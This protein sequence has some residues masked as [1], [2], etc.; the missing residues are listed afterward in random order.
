M[1]E[2]NSI[3]K[4]LMHKP[5]RED[6]EKHQI[7]LKNLNEKISQVSKKYDYIYFK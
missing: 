5:F 4:S 3:Q 7:F 6:S 1:K 2:I